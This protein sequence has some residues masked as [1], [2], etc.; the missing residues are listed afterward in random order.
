MLVLRVQALLHLVPV[1][2]DITDVFAGV[3][4]A[5]PLPHTDAGLCEGDCGWGG[6]LLLGED[7]QD[8]AVR[9]AAVRV[10]PALERVELP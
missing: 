10:S 7:V 6:P 5:L 8:G 9:T 4:R 3:G 1:G 2:L